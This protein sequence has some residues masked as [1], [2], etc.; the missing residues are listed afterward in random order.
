[1]VSRRGR[2]A[3]PDPGLSAVVESCGSTGDGTLDV[4]VVG[5]GL[6][7]EGFLAEQAPPA[8]LEV[9]PAGAT[10]SGTGC[11]RGCSVSQAWIGP[12]VWLLRLS[13]MT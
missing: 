4:V 10:G 9:Q 12:L 8:L 2:R 7:G 13:A 6:A 5:E 11:T 3:A 1:M